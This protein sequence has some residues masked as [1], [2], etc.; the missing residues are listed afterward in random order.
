MNGP[1]HIRAAEQSLIGASANSTSP[2]MFDRH[3][4]IA[5][6]HMEMARLLLDVHKSAVADQLLGCS[7]I[8]SETTQA[9]DDAVY[10]SGLDWIGVT[11]EGGAR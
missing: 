2:Q 3:V 10:R 1:E 7:E 5:R 9:R 11:T 6:A 4:R 8:Y